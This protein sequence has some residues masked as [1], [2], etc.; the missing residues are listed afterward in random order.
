MNGI[1]LTVISI[2][3]IITIPELIPKASGGIMPP[4]SMRASVPADT[5][6]PHLSRRARRL[7]DGEIAGRLMQ[8][9]MGA[10]GMLSN[11]KVCDISGYVFVVL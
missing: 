7:R 11:T 2:L 1:L 10:V 6:P 3:Q 5:A 4:H 8:S 9:Q